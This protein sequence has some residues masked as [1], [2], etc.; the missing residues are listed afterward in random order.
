MVIK[1]KIKLHIGMEEKNKKKNS[2]ELKLVVFLLVCLFLV[3]SL[4]LA[5][6]FGFFGAFSLFDKRTLTQEVKVSY[7]E[8][9]NSIF[10]NAVK[11][12]QPV[13]N[14]VVSG[15]KITKTI[16]KNGVSKKVTIW[17]A[18]LKMDK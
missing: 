7:A 18:P 17:T 1:F 8:E 6:H 11:I 4:F 2:E 3:N 15:N 10:S 12:V 9:S 16:V 5:G 13:K 14:L